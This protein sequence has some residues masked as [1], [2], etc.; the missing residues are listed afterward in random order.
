M[1]ERMLAVM[2]RRGELLAKI[3][4]QRGQL[5]RLAEQWKTPLAVASQ[6]VGV[7]RYLCAHPVL[8]AGVTVGMAVRRR[9]MLGVLRVAWRAW[10]GYRYFIRLAEKR[11]PRH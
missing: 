3:E 4:V 8:L 2:Q 10:K 11:S 7:V 9:G 1:N 5:G 6:G